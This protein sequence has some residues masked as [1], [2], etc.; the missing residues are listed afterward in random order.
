M[1]IKTFIMA[2]AMSILSINASV[3][4]LPIK[5]VDGKEYYYYQVKPKETMYSLSHRFE[6][7]QEE[8]IKYNPSLVDGLK[9]GAILY[10][11]VDEL[12]YIDM[13]IVHKVAK[14]ESVYGI[15]KQY[16]MLIDDLLR[17]NPSAK[18]GIKVGEELV[19]KAATKKMVAN[20]DV[21]QYEGNVDLSVECDPTL[22]TIKD[23]DTSVEE[24][25]YDEETIY[26]VALFMP[27]MLNQE[28]MNTAT[29]TYLDFYKG[30]LLAA[31]A[32]KESGNKINVY[33]YDTYNSIDSLKNIMEQPD[34]Q[35]MNVIIAPPGN[36]SSVK[37]IA[38]ACDKS[39]AVFNAFY[40]NDTTHLDKKNVIQA[41]IVRDEMYDKAISWLVNEYSDYTPL[42]IGSPANKNRASMV[43]EIKSRYKAKGVEAKEIIFGR[44]LNLVNLDKLDK[45]TKYLVIPLSSSEKEF[46][47]YIEALKEFK[48]LCT[49]D[50]VLFGYPEWITFKDTQRANLH[51]LNTVVYSRF[52]FN[53][54]G[55]AEQEF[56][57]KFLDVYKA[58]MKKSPPIQAVLG[59]DCGYYII[60]ALRE[61]NGNILDADLQYTGLQYTF[62]L[63][64]PTGEKGAEN[65]SLYIIRYQLNNDVDVTVL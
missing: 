40:A 62:D 63:E 8:M 52:Y 41:N 9:S 42:I 1:K 47:K 27:F 46:D 25:A 35:T 59:Y 20:V 39:T 32:L 38:N 2:V 29:R 15:S 6:M 23:Y 11:P 43:D 13:P 30:F 53:E 64:N 19:I 28:T 4:E 45:K 31:D 22:T 48:N 5:V 10:F 26:N 24:I 49:E 3:Y 7:S 18:D 44:N 12:S 37:T 33:A 57:Q 34:I 65:K 61:G 14:G 60:N 51:A 36:V 50:V 16:G 56:T 58:P 55:N 17:L 54:T 21:K